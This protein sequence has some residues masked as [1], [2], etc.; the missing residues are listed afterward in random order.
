MLGDDEIVSLLTSSA[1]F[2]DA[3]R[4]AAKK[5]KGARVD[6]RMFR[7]WMSL[8]AQSNKLLAA[9]PGIYSREISKRTGSGEHVPRTVGVRAM[10]ALDSDG[11]TVDSFTELL[12]EFRASPEPEQA[13]EQEEGASSEPPDTT[14]AFVDID[15]AQFAADLDADQVELLISALR[16]RSEI[17]ATLLEATAVEVRAGLSAPGLP[18]DVSSWNNLVASTWAAFGSSNVPPNAS[19]EVLEALRERIAASELDAQAEQVTREEKLSQLARLRTTAAGLEPMAGSEETFHSAYLL[20]CAQISDLEHELGITD[21]DTPEPDASDDDFEDESDDFPAVDDDDAEVHDSPEQR[22]VLKNAYPNEATTS[23]EPVGTDHN[24]EPGTVNPIA[25]AQADIE[26]ATEAT[27]EAGPGSSV[28]QD[29]PIAD[30]A[31][32]DHTANKIDGGTLQ[33]Q[34]NDFAEDLAAHVRAGRFGAAWLVAQAAGLPELEV[35]AYRLAAAAF[36][37]VPGGI[38]P[39]EVLIGITGAMSDSR[40]ISC[41]SARLALAA[42]LRAALAA[43]WSPRSELET[44]ENHANLGTEWHDLV[45][46]SVAA[47]DRNYQHLQ[48]FGG[49][50]E[51]A[52]D[53]LQKNARNVRGEMMDLRIKFARADKVLKYLLR[54]NEPLGAAFEAILADTTGSQRREALTEVLAKLDSPDDVIE[55]TDAIV[56]KSQQRQYPIQSHARARLRRAVED[57]AECVAQALNAAVVVANDSRAAVAQEAHRNLLVAAQAVDVDLGAVGPGDVSLAHLVNWILSPEP[58]PRFITELE[59]LLDESLP[60][61][62]APRD[63]NG[64]PLVNTDNAAAVVTD[65]RVPRAQEDLFD[66]YLSRGD[67]QQAR[68]LAERDPELQDRFITDKDMWG[69]RLTNE[70]RALRAD[71]ARTY[72]DEA[73]VGAQVDAEAQLVTPSEYKGD[74]FDLQ[75]EELTRLRITLAEHRAAAADVLSRRVSEEVNNA[76]DRERIDSLI[77]SE[78]FVG[79]NELLALARGGALPDLDVEDSPAGALVFDAFAQALLS[80]DR[81][82]VNSIHDMVTSFAHGHVDDATAHGDLERLRSWDNLTSPRRGQGSRSGWQGAL[83]SIL[84]ALGLDSRGEPSRQPLQGVR[85]FELYRVSA[86][87]L[88]G[89]LVPGLGSQATHYMVATT[90]DR[91]LLRETLGSGFP[92][93]NG[94]NIVLFDGVLSMEERGQCLN[95]CREKRISAIVVD[96]AVAAFV[97]ARHPRSFRAVQQIT[98]PFTCFTH[99]TVVA[100]NVP[101]EVFVGRNDELHQLTD[102]AGS[103]FVYGGRQLGKSA[104]LRKIQR[105]FNAEPD[106]HAIFID[107]NS[108]GIGTW[109]D[110]QRLWPVLYNELAK[111]GSMGIKQNP[112]VRNHDAV[113]RPIRQWLDDK[114]SRRLLL[115]L[116][117]ADAFLEKES[118]QAPSGFQNIGP[119]KGLFDDTNGHFKPVFAGLHKV[120]RLQNV[121]NTPLAHGGRDV[122]VGPLAAKPARDLVVKPLEALGY[123]FATPE[124]VWR[125]LAFTNLQPGLIQVVCN[126]LV[127]HLQSRPLRNGEPLVVISD[128]DIDK[129]TGDEHTRNKITEKL[130]LTISLED[131]YRVI[132]LA[133]AIMSMGDNF[134]ASYSAADIRSHCTT[135]WKQGF[136][137]LNSA[138]FEVYLDELIGLGVL[139]KDRDNLYSV[140]SPNIVTMLGTKEDLETELQESEEQFELPHEYNPRSTRRQVAIDNSIVRSPLSEHDLSQIMPV[141]TKYAPSNFIILGSDALGI[142][143]V[144]RVLKLV[145][146]DRKINVTSLDS[147]TDDVSDILSTFKWSAGGIGAPR[148]VIVDASRAGALAAGEINRAVLSVQRRAH[149]HLIVIYG[150]EGVAAARSLREMS[151]EGATNLLRL[152]KWSGDGIRAWHD[153]PFNLPGDRRELLIHSSGWPELVERA[154][155]EV[156][157]RGV[158]HAEEWERLS[159]FPE[160]TS[161][162]ADFLRRVGVGDD[163]LPLVTQWAQLGS[164][165]H[166]RISDIGAVLEFNSDLVEELNSLVSDLVLLDAVHEYNGEYLLD[167]VVARAVN[168]LT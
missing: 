154:V 33:Q 86:T 133:V 140:R 105:D 37:S 159:Q 29:S 63:G 87:P 106:H 79:A 114:S 3:V 16:E 96:H 127:V 9:M 2:R 126:D 50:L 54:S 166:E 168:K 151:R 101:D 51:L 78:D 47:T 27:D 30:T 128:A 80:L 41:Q 124:S 115:L 83:A 130:R 120:Q 23:P 150:A 45:S 122:L 10:L 119:L 58:S 131:R 104:L 123:R 70:V 66:I 92:T 113:I 46:A 116:D 91:K 121:A 1:D 134:R 161:S 82:E 162:A 89:S 137:D 67:L 15:L 110:S 156:S 19:F 48:D 65:L 141:Q 55:A 68:A 26:T 18:D 117:E 56:N 97:A 100:G 40:G 61:V 143:H 64:L 153:N 139:I 73:T 36:H 167:P 94:P 8:P 103:L 147:T 13:P 88:D 81:S 39:A 25:A 85:H 6:A 135:Y 69:R 59:P 72:A 149:G 22:V 99:Y 32:A 157:Y 49:H 132:A 93:N 158:G 14:G 43:G 163:Q 136:T 24:D 102:R 62:S 148:A 34:S 152:E 77:R 84:R 125:L 107:L 109:A 31:I 98:L 21:A 74:R 4:T 145:G 118:S 129:V 57:T 160:S 52:I 60:V 11:V 90:A 71:I 35:N 20:A 155:D 112:S 53:D 75:M 144:G 95:V 7:L 146:E 38:D 142:N 138:G 164:K 111:I 17:L 44:I 108:H 5:P 28:N 12:A 76:V 42:T 165:G